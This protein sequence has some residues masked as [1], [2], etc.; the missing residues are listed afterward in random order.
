M[1]K[2]GIYRHFKGK[3]Y[4]VIGFVMNAITNKLDVLYVPL[5]QNPTYDQYSRDMDDFIS[6]VLREN[7]PEIENWIQ[8]ERF[9]CLNGST[10][11][12][13]KQH[14]YG[15]VYTN[16][17]TEMLTELIGLSEEDKV[18][19]CFFYFR[20]IST[21][22]DGKTFV[23]LCKFGEPYIRVILDSEQKFSSLVAFPKLFEEAGETKAECVMDYMQKIYSNSILVFDD[24]VNK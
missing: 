4:R 8:D 20:N 22:K 14:K 1:L 11:L 23:E 5:Y 15:S 19:D 9:L 3:Y 13:K 2:L 6:D 21:D 16:E 7:Y 10:Y 24:S 17:S 12:F 18:R